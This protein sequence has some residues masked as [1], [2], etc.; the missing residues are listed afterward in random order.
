MNFTVS[1]GR[2]WDGGVQEAEAAGI[3]FVHGTV[4]TLIFILTASCIREVFPDAG[5]K[6]QAGVSPRDFINIL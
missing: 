5:I 4:M 2:G 3:A 6:L 1:H